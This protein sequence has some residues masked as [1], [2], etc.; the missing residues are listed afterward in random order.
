LR[1]VEPL[2]Y[3]LGVAQNG[4]ERC[5]QLVA[6]VG[7]ELVFVLARDLEVLDGFGK[8]AGS[9]L[10]FFEKARVFNRDHGLVGEGVDEFDLAFGEWAHFGAPNGDHPNCLVCVDQRDAEQGA[11]TNS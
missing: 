11:I 7:H 5:P 2:L 8:L 3:E 6:H 9:R 10:H 1:L 4:R